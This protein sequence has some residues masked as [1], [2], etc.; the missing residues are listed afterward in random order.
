MLSILSSISCLLC[1]CRHT[2][3]L[4]S[5]PATFSKEQTQHWWSRFETLA[6]PLMRAALEAGVMCRLS[7]H[8]RL[9]PEPLSHC[10][11]T[12][13]S[14]QAAEAKAEAELG[15]ESKGSNGG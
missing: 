3:L 4:K 15:S 8:A 14:N 1:H 2:V 7:I 10:V 12:E 13:A 5:S 6:L 11:Q 9:S